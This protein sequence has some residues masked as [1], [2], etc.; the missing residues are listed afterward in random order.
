MERKGER[1]RGW[2]TRRT[3]GLWG[4]PPGAPQAARQEFRLEPP[5]NGQQGSQID[6]FSLCF[7]GTPIKHL[8]DLLCILPASYSLVISSPLLHS[9]FLLLHLS[10][11]QFS[12]N[13]VQ[14]RFKFCFSFL[15]VIFG[16]QI[17]STIFKRPILFSSRPY[18]FKSV[19]VCIW[20]SLFDNSRI[21]FCF[22][23][24]GEDRLFLLLFWGFSPVVQSHRPR[25]TLDVVLPRPG[26]RDEDCFFQEWMGFASVVHL[27]FIFLEPLSFMT[28][29]SPSPL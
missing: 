26:M 23:W 27:R 13:I 19:L 20:Q 8:L 28:R 4:I 15:E 6:P 1:K 24:W 22:F 14:M 29:G 16:F 9:A 10:V 17:C 5:G 3:Q 12:F 25:K 2:L 18:I 21:C 7:S 11:P